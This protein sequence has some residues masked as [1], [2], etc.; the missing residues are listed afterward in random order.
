MMSRE[1]RGP[2]GSSEHAE[3]TQQAINETHSSPMGARACA[4]LRCERSFAQLRR[5]LHCADSRA[6]ALSEARAFDAPASEDV[7]AAVALA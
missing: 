2:F 5:T 7:F 1:T 3:S 6:R 4:S